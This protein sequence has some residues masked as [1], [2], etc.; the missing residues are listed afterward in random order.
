MVLFTNEIIKNLEKMAEAQINTMRKVNAMYTCI[1]ESK[2]YDEYNNC[3][4]E[5]ARD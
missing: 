3:V 2:T 1:V 4:R 5:K